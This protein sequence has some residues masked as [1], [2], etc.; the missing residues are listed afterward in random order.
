M[1]GGVDEGG[2]CL[3]SR[4]GH[5]CDSRVAGKFAGGTFAGSIGRR[6]GSLLKLD[7]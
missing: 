1:I 5:V 4:F 3:R 7:L 6:F 2:D